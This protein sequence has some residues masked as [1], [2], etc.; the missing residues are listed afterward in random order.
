M[1]NKRYIIRNNFKSPC[2]LMTQNPQNPQKVVYKTFIKG[3]VVTGEMKKDKQ[4]NPAALVV[5]EGFVIPTSCIQELITK[6]VILSNASG[7][8]KKE[9]TI[10]VTKKSGDRMKYVDSAIVGAVLGF[11]AV[12]FAEKKN[13]LTPN[14]NN[15]YIGIAIGLVLTPYLVY[16][17]SPKVTVTKT[18]SLT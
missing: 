13:W 11:G 8:D 18:E 5:G 10:S 15:K 12:Y 4:G 9:E 6:D 2:V 16:R 17:F 3:Q 14:P 1:K 7:N